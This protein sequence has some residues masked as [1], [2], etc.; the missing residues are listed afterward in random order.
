[1]QKHASCAV[2]AAA[3]ALENSAVAAHAALRSTCW[4]LQARALELL[5]K[6]GVPVEADELLPS[7]LRRD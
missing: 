6:L 1:M 7:F 3:L 5:G 2:R 4:L